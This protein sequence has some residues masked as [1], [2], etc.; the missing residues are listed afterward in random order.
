MIR[1]K[2]QG[3]IQPVF[4]PSPTATRAALSYAEEA[5]AHFSAGRMNKA[6]IA[7]KQATTS[8]PTNTKYWIALSRLQV[9]NDQLE[10][11]LESAET[12]ILIEPENSMAHAIRALALDWLFELEEAS[13]A[14][15]RAI[16]LDANNA[17]AHAFY[18][19]ILTDMQKYGPAGDEVRLALTLNPNN[20]DVHRVHGYYLESVG[21]YE[22]AILAY[23]TAATINPNISSLYMQLGV[24][25]RVIGQYETAIEYFTRASAL[26]PT[27]YGPYISISRTLSQTGEYGRAIQYL[28]S[29]LEL[30][31][32]SA[33][34]Y[35]RMGIIKFRSLNYEGALIDLGC[36]VEGCTRTDSGALVQGLPLNH[37]SLEYYYTYG[38]VLAAYLECDHALNIFDRVSAFAP[39]DKVIK[40]IKDEN[41]AICTDTTS[42]D[43]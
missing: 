11:A 26:D 21:A 7:Y 12:A 2:Q 24:N 6:V 8:E 16:Q 37:S 15:V 4:I 17:L 23:Q 38:S 42:P 20:V 1:L 36:A 39:E 19:E 3:D 9:Y 28:E 13:R 10:A 43:T 22:D 29:A 5:E 32:N 34:I 30:D 35:G 33:D 31:E 27:N 18:A 40:D 14:A 41:V 25:Y